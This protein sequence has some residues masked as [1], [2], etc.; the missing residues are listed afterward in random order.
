[1]GGH[2]LNTRK[3]RILRAVVEEY[4]FT[5]EPVGSRTISRRYEKNLSSAT[6]R[7]EMADLEEM[8]FLEQP[9][10]SRPAVFHPIEDIVFM[11]IIL[12]KI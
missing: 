3:Q 1:M 4:I 7:N 8:G 5:A 11:W 9:P 10:T 12:W 6:I 2:I